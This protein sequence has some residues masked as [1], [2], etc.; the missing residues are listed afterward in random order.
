[1][2]VWESNVRVFGKRRY[3]RRTPQDATPG[4]VRSGRAR[5]ERCAPGFSRG[6]AQPRGRLGPKPPQRQDTGS[7]GR[8]SRMAPMDVVEDRRAEDETGEPRRTRRTDPAGQRG[9]RVSRA[10]A[11]GRPPRRSTRVTGE[12]TGP[13][14][15]ASLRKRRGVA[16][17]QAIAGARRRSVRRL[18]PSRSCSTTGRARRNSHARAW[19][20]TGDRRQAGELRHTR[21]GGSDSGP[22]SCLRPRELNDLGAIGPWRHAG[23]PTKR[24]FSRRAFKTGP[25]RGE[26]NMAAREVPV[27]GDDCCKR[28]LAD[29]G[30]L[31]PDTVCA[32]SI[33]EAVARPALPFCRRRARHL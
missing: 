16:Q 20:R 2:P 31:L 12:P 5:R 14:R 10:A 17:T 29:R 19:R 11:V 27:A 25:L 7:V 3:R 30:C 4:A 22:P 33:L 8:A 18:A 1:M 9:R 13:A 26:R 28:P 32:W 24:T 23:K 6:D 15:P 21:N